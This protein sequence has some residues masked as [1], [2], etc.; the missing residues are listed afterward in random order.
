VVV[1]IALRF[2]VFAPK[3][4]GITAYVVKPGRV[5]DTVTNSKAGTVKTRKRAS[6][7]PETGGRVVFIGAREGQHVK[8]GE[9]LLR[10]QDSD[11][12][13]SL[14]LAERAFQSAEASRN[15]ACTEAD[16]AR[17]EVDRNKPLVAE[18]VVP[19]SQLDRLQNQLEVA[20]ARCEAGK[21]ESKRAQAAIDVANAVLQ[22]TELRA[23]FDGVVSQLHTEVGEF[24]T[25]SPPG[26]PIPPVIDLLDNKSIYV[27]APMDE[28]DSGKL[29]TGLPVRI[30]LDP[31]PGKSFGGVLSRV[32]PFVL[33]VAGQ[34]RTVDIE[35]EFKDA[36][37]ARQLLPGTSA[38]VEVILQSQSD[39]L[40]IPTYTLM[41]GNFVLLI[42]DNKLVKRAVKT[43]LRNWEFVEITNGL[44]DGDRIAASLD[45][46]EVKEGAPI[47]V[48]AETTR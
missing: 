21:A 33:D 14:A 19:S 13:A 25:P 9:V 7:S 32:A 46:A 23:P 20:T 37:F 45:R 44:K 3:S 41:E 10:L 15:Q 22:K 24:V 36:E 34:S 18:G 31:F 6:L 29:H 39:V 28:T 38:D 47:K 26:V 8:A 4:I 30:T 43:G 5:E 16:L 17:R 12:R 2:T 27:E 40:R 42:Q 48:D 1:I 35:A 11:T